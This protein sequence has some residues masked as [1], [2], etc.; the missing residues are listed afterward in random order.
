MNSNAFE[1]NFDGI[2]GP[3][4][5]YSGLSY[6]NLASMKH[7]EQ[8]SN[9]REAALQGLQKMRFLHEKG[10]KQA[11][12]PPH[13]RPYIPYL[14]SLGFQGRESD[15]I[16][17]AANQDI[18]L[19]YACCSAS[20]MW[21]ANAATICPS[22]DS[23]DQHLHFT[24]ANLSSTFHRSLEADFT[25]HLLKTIFREPVFFSHHA[26]LHGGSFLADEG[27]AN[28]TRF[29]KKYGD[30]GIQLFLFG[31]HGTR[32]NN[33]AP[34]IYPARQTF[35]A[36]QAVARLH[37]LYPNRA[38]I[39]Q[40]NP[41]AIDLGVFHN[42]VIAVGNLNVFLYHEAAFLDS[43][44]LIEEIRAKAE[45]FCDMEM[46]FIPIM[47]EMLSIEEAVSCYLF[48]SQLLSLPDGSMFLAAP[49]ECQQNEKVSEL[50]QQLIEQP[51]NPIKE[52]HYFNLI[53]S[54]QNGG[55][56][57]CMRLRIVLNE[58]ELTAMQQGV[59]MSDRLYDRLT[60]WVRKHYRDQLHP[61][62][63]ADPKLLT[64]VQ[65]ALDELTRILNIGHI[66]SFQR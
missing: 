57:A 18:E 28:H 12:L 48:N 30:P 17:Q 53:Q 34:V 51:E 26:P 44:T 6:G 36:S 47:E 66:Y 16:N 11:V 40:Q 4:H 33:V 59:M 38:I 24:P 63:L 41:E 7:A 35:E 23:L 3:T 32:T 50:I 45:E 49:I 13:E 62:D 10:L 54:M 19:Y 39:A 58:R 8:V 2:V 25:A 31:R 55:G 1:V 64:E 52:V 9:P 61:H 60:E 14:K 56:P 42:D 46:I 65:H 21:A 27:A 5:N 37:R 43:G 20:A 29:A 15:I 22:S